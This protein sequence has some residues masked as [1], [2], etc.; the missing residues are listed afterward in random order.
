MSQNFKESFVMIAKDIN[1]IEN[2]IFN[3]MQSYFSEEENTVEYSLEPNKQS[4][5]YHTFIKE[6]NLNEDEHFIV[7]IALAN[8]ISSKVFDPF[9]SKNSLYDMPYSEFGGSK[10][11]N[12][13]IFVPTIQTIMFLLCGSNIALS[14]EKRNLFN[15]ESKLYKNSIL[16]LQSTDSFLQT[17]IL[18]TQSAI[19]TLLGDENKAYDYSKEFPAQKIQSNYTWDDLVTSDYTKQH[20]EELELWIKHHNTLLNDWGMKKSLTK[21][22]KALF[23]GPPGTGKSLTATLLGK[24]LGKEVYRISLSQIV[25]KYIGETEKNLEKVFL[26]AQDHDWILFFDEADAL[27]GKR[28]GVNSSNDKYANQGTSYL[29]QRIEECDNMIIL[30]SNLKDNFDEAY[31]RR[32]QSIIYFGLPEY[33]ERLQLW[34]QGFSDTAILDNIN[35]E[36]IANEYELSGASIM[37]VI[38]Y[39]SLMAIKD[40]ENKILK[41]NIITAIKREKYKEGKII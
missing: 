24:K 1:N 4:N 9:L 27:F 29:L 25:S 13:D 36:E 20:L 39:A 26:K 40:K 7:L 19:H 35:L 11:Y 6:N 17:P 21:G 41:K 28:T 8:E 34:K 22:Y 16:Q 12:S 23:Y 5:R 38:R 15:I 31:L 2:F 14:I 18:L 30:A 33:E 3:R 32:F 37:N 10:K